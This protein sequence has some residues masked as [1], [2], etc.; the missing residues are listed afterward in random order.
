MGNTGKQYEILTQEIFGV[1]LNQKGIDTI[2]VQ[3]D[4]TL[5]GKDLEHQIECILGVQSWRDQIC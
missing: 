3:H 5:K 1:M 4:I 2:D